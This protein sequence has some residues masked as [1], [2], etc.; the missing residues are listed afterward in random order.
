M[1]YQTI[2]FDLDGTLTEPAE[3]I[4][5]SVA[6]ALAKFGITVTDREELLRFI[7]PPLMD[8]FMEYYGFDEAKARQ[9]VAYYR[10]YFSVKGLFENSVIQGIKEL[11]EELQAAGKQ[12]VVATSKPEYFSLQILEKFGLLS[13]FTFVA[14]ATM[15]ETRTRKADV[16]AYAL[17]HISYEAKASTVMVGDRHHDVEGARALGLDAIGVTF[18][19]GSREE[20]QGAGATYVVDTI[21]QLRQRLL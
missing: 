20:L 8:S 16:I 11:L 15:D 10:E 17:E 14:G 5:N 2:L 6:Y 4:T 1:S 13:Y 3:G 18:G 7:G 12:L 19:Y 21:A 9:A